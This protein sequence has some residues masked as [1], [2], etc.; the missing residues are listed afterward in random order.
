[1]PGFNRQAVCALDAPEV[2][3]LVNL[4]LLVGAAD[5]SR[6]QQHDVAS[7]AAADADAA[8]ARPGTGA[9]SGREDAC[10]R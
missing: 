7:A 3:P 1:M 2:F 5:V 4:N 10:E 6:P 8:A 9:R